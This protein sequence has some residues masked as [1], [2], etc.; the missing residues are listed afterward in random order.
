MRRCFCFT[1]IAM[2]AGTMLSAAASAQ[3]TFGQIDDFQTTGDVLTL[4]W[5]RGA[6]APTAP[7]NTYPNVVDTGGPEGND[8]YL[9]LYSTGTSGSGSRMNMFNENQWTGNYL[10]AGVTLITAQM[11]DFTSTPLY[12][13][14]AIQDDIGTEYGSTNAAFVPADG[15]WQQVSFDLHTSGLTPLQGTHPLT[16][17]L[18]TVGVLRLLSNQ[19]GPSFQGDIRPG[20]IGIDE[21]A[22]VPEPGMLGLLGVLAAV[23][24]RRAPDRGR[25]PG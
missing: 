22:A 19:E 18:T 8:P 21:I 16:V 13:R 9:L 12:M 20:S 6:N 25:Q 7:I 23:Y 3:I 11:A 1:C 4:G 17:A 10:A 5:T 15:Q 24:R 14:I 2:A